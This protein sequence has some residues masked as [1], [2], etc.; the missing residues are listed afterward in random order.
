M[1]VPGSL[2]FNESSES[3]PEQSR[4]VTATNPLK[5]PSKHCVAFFNFSMYLHSFFHRAL[6][7]AIGINLCL[8]GIFTSNA[9]AAEQIIFKYQRLSESLSVKELTTFAMTGK[10]SPKLEVY[11]NLLQ[12]DPKKLRQDLTNQVS[13]SPLALNQFL[14][15]WVGKLTLDEASQIIRPRSTQASKQALRSA[16][17]LSTA[18]DNKFS[19]VEVFQNY[20]TAQVEVDIDRLIQ[21][22]RRIN[23]LS[24]VAQPVAAF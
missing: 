8:A 7:L 1:N 24:Q 15:S 12:G 4:I 19:L 3:L 6:G 14:D 5:P 9:I 23:T 2:T 10:T 18:K 20:P 13:I 16:I 17:A 22:D 21:T 11:L